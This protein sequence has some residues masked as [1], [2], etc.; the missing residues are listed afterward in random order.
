MKLGQLL[1]LSTNPGPGM[2]M[3]PSEW[4][5]TAGL[6]NGQR[7]VTYLASGAPEYGRRVYTGALPARVSSQCGCPFMVF[8]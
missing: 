6:H 7:H 4:L 5:A 1:L 3:V 2:G 8:I